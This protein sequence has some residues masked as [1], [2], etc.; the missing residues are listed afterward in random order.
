MTTPLQLKLFGSPRI[1]YQG[2]PLTGF[3]STKVR[4]LLIYLAVTGR[5]HSRDH[6]AELLWADT[7]AST[8]ANLRKALSNLR[9]L[10]GNTLV[11]DAKESIALNGAQVWVDVVEFGRLIKGGAAQEAVTLYQADFLT[12]FNLSLS[13]EFEA[14]ALSEQSR[15]KTQMVDLLRHLATQ[16]EANSK[17]SE[18]IQT[19]RRLLALE[20]WQEEAHRWL[21]EL[22]AKN[23]Q[24]SAALAHFEVCKRV[25]QEELAVAPSEETVRLVENFQKSTSQINNQLFAGNEQATLRSNV[26]LASHFNLPM[27]STPLLGREEDQRK[28]INLLTASSTRLITL[29]GAPGIGKTR[30]G[31]AVANQLKPYFADGVYFV[32]LAAIVDPDLV[33]LT[34]IT[35]LRIRIGERQSPQECLTSFLCDKEM[36]LLLDNFEQVVTAAPLVTH[37]LHECPSVRIVVTSRERLRLS[38]EQIFRVP[39]LAMTDAINL[40]VQ[41]VRALDIDFV[42][43]QD[44]QPLLR[45][46]CQHLDCL[47]LAIE[48]NAAQ[49]EI[50]SP[51]ALLSHLRQQRLDLLGES[52]R[53]LPDRQL[54]LRNAIQSSYIRLNTREKAL[55]RALGVCVGSFDQAFVEALGFSISIL[56]SLIYKSLVQV[57]TTKD[58]VR[59]FML[60]ETLREFAREQLEHTSEIVTIERCHADFYLRLAENA[61]AH[62][63]TVEQGNW[64]EQV[65]LEYDNLRAALSWSIKNCEAQIGGRLGIA[66]RGFW[67]TRG[68][69]A[70]G[71]QWLDRLLAQ[72]DH[73]Q[74]RG[75]LLYG[76]ARLSRRMGNHDAA[77]SA[78]TES[79]SLFRQV[80][81]SEGIASALRGLGMIYFLQ[82]DAQAQPLFEESLAIFRELNDPEGI[83]AALDG[84]AYA[85]SNSITE[86]QQYF[87][88]SLAVRRR[89]GNTLGMTISLNGL[90]HMAL[91]LGDYTAA[92]VYQ[93]EHHQI[94]E[95]LGNLNGIANAMY[96]SGLISFAE[97]NF[98]EAHIQFDKCLTICQ[99]TGDNTIPGAIRALGA[100]SLKKGDFD[101]AE[102]LFTRALLLEHSLDALYGV[103]VGIGYFACLAAFRGQAWR[104]LCLLGA[105]ESITKSWERINWLES[106]EML[107]A[108]TEARRL[109]DNSEV[110]I[111]K[112]AGQAMTLKEAID[113]ALS[114]TDS[115]KAS[116]R[117]T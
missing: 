111:A 83:A 12:G 97:E 22:L 4:A 55:F 34:I 44:N 73:P 89:A 13:Y 91:E 106:R 49:I 68:Q 50:L 38:I 67:G 45:E 59:R 114:I 63:R 62:F 112:G 110:A 80:N 9:Q 58:N 82:D 84:I 37:L 81:D 77:I 105:V 3:V 21:M 115:L 101:L 42:L 28:V 85:A 8:R 74:V 113:Y 6:L 93:T 43:T 61:S 109:I 27:Q 16:Q 103:V 87:Q 18:A 70:E 72:V 31:I 102:R 25:L 71:W 76:Q 75:K 52:P 60:L 5:P 19:V 32:P 65:A 95:R 17:R 2:Q 108:E 33:A 53:D 57:V 40:F 78:Y 86:A 116:T 20:P 11:E 117:L 7:P 30:L 35:V 64:L 26:S 100:T 99:T 15:L 51:V 98:D 39:T 10:I 107:L 96:L 90:A 23:G 69:Y 36:L 88:E 92:R 41:R 94:N 104:A 24:R 29:V 56:Q 1:S 46:I 48:L 47:P 54:T 66:L 14:W 79:L